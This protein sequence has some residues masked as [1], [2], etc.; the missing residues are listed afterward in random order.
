MANPF[1]SIPPEWLE[2][3][4]GQPP[5]PA[6]PDPAFEQARAA[7]REAQRK[8]DLTSAFTQAASLVRN[9]PVA[10]TPFRQVGDEG[11]RAWMAQ[12]AAQGAEQDRAFRYGDPLRDL[13]MLGVRGEQEAARAAEAAK[14]RGEERGEERAW[15]EGE[16]AKDRE[17]R[18][19][20]LAAAEE[21]R[22]SAAE[23]RAAMDEERK[24]RGAQR[25]TEAEAKHYISENFTATS[26][27]LPPAVQADLQKRDAAT[28]VVLD[29]ASQLE[30][31]L[32]EG[33]PAVWGQR[34]G[35]MEMLANNIWTELKD[36]KGLGV[37]A[38]PDMAIL[39][40]I[41]ADPTKVRSILKDAS[42]ARDFKQIVQQFQQR[43]K[44]DAVRRAKNYGAQPK[45]GGVY[46]T[47]PTTAP[48]GA[49][50]VR[51]PQRTDPVTGETRE[52]DG[53]RWVPVGGQ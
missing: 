27:P 1:A 20:A 24:A 50:P 16:S 23:S 7:D 45:E 36:I 13:T 35:Q 3:I 32:T 46:F 37:L 4:L 10:P 21:A 19:Q 2:K 25:Q 31:L 15:R 8:A 39:Q 44:D 28:A 52:W 43:V 53:A 22:R 33:G 12:K 42:G 51:R 38:G 17:L 47:A 48:A 29:N 11:L 5:A 40:G 49:A 6:G 14:L 41:L 30:A 18:R 26:T 9:Q 34:A